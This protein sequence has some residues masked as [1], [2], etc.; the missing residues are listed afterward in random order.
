M[1]R[2]PSV[3]LLDSDSGTA[4]EVADSLA[5]LVHFNRKYGGIA[6][7]FAMAEQVADGLRQLS[8]LEVAAGAGTVPEAV[9]ERMS[10]RGVKVDVTLLDRVASHLK[11]DI[12]ENGRRTVVGD[13][14]A[15]PL[16]DA[17]FDV[18]S[19]CLFVHHLAPEEVVRFVREGLR[20]CRKA[21]LIN[22]LVRSRLHLAIVLAGLPT[23]RSRI[24]RNDAPASVRQAYTT[25]EMQTMVKEAGAARVEVQRHFLYRMGVV[26]WKS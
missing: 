18:V 22:D 8:W 11:N 16:A 4:T 25:E 13:A 15:L 17:S 14:L 19:C 5:D 26:A 20:V 1:K 9:A 12:R 2:V 21:V 3:E 7:T 6:T 23:Y 24:T 10:G